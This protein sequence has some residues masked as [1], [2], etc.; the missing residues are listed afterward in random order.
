VVRRHP[1]IKWL[2]RAEDIAAFARQ[3]TRLLEA[4]WQVLAADGRMLYVTCSVFREENADRIDA[5]LA[6]HADAMRMPVAGG[7]ELLPDAEHDGFFYA[8]LARSR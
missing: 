3:Q 6:Q 5:F 4:L 8:L 7:G 2:R 1:D